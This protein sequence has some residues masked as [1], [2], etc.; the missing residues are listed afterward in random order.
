LLEVS[1]RA[2]VP[3]RSSTSSSARVRFKPGCWS[4]TRTEASAG[5]W[6]T[7]KGL[8]ALEKKLQHLVLNQTPANPPAGKRIQTTEQGG[9]LFIENGVLKL[10]VD[11]K[12][13]APLLRVWKDG[14]LVSE[15]GLDILIK[16][17]AG[18]KFST[19]N[20]AEARFEIEESG[21]LRL[22]M[23]WSAKHKRGRP[24]LRRK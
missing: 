1:C 12:R 9:L 8:R 6:S 10:E 17:P 15:G 23:N 7:I 2:I 5:C 11:R 3:L 18:E 21:P 13:C 22:L 19:R 16:S 20:D 4:G 24:V 14:Q